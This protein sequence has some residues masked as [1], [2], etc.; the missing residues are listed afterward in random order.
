MSGWLGLAVPLCEDDEVLRCPIIVRVLEDDSGLARFYTGVGQNVPEERRPAVSEFITRVN[1]STRTGRLDLDFRDGEV[2]YVTQMDLS[3]GRELNCGL[4][5][6]KIMFAVR[7]MVQSYPGLMAVIH[8][9]VDP[10][11]ASAGLE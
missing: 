7:L 8:Q 4:F 11:G 1:W 9:G 2:R 5:M 6:E 3:T 10:E